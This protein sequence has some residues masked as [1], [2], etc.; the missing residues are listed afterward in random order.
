MFYA[1]TDNT[2]DE[3]CIDIGAAVLAFA[4]REEAE[5][6]LKSPYHTGEWD[7]SD[8]RIIEGRF[9]DSWLR[10]YSNRLDPTLEVDLRCFAPFRAEDLCVQAP[11]THPGGNCY[12]ITPIPRVLVLTGV[13]PID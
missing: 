3:T 10:L 9:M 7:L 5:E 4:E 12:W 6:Y 8:A 1:T 2:V 11:G 13:K